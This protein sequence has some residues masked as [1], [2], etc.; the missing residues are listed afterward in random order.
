MLAEQAVLEVRAL[1]VHYGKALALDGVEIDVPGH[2]S[3][4]VSGCAG[5]L[6]GQY[7]LNPSVAAGI[8]GAVCPAE[9]NPF[10]LVA[11]SSTSA[12]G[13]LPSLRAKLMA[14]VA[15]RPIR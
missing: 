9:F 10:D 3:L 14:D 13:L 5:A 4:G 8:D 12:E 2:T 6:T 1:T 15:F 7:L 11:S